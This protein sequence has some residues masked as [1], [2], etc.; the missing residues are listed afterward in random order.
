MKQSATTVID[1]ALADEL[2][3][4]I[5]GAAPEK[6]EALESQLLKM[7]QV[8]IPVKEGLANEMYTRE[9]LIP[10]GT[11]LTGRVHKYPYVDIMLSGDITVATPDGVKR[12]TGANVCDG[13]PGRKRAGFAH[14]DT[15]WVTVH[16]TDQVDL[17]D[18]IEYLTFVSLR[19]FHEWDDR[20]DFLLMAEDS[21]YTIQE[22]RA[23]SENESDRLDLEISTIRVADSGIEGL[24]LFANQPFHA[25]DVICPARVSGMRT[26]AGRYTNH[27]KRP[28]CQMVAY[29]DGNVFLKAIKPILANQELT[30]NY[31]HVRSQL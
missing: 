10:K 23:Q 21:G 25:G 14:Q 22:I 8:E 31:A 19:E 7:P 16:R 26:Q 30:V 5:S 29:P 24:G 9:I 28:N 3:D 13:V 17:D 15:R 4:L 6:I 1:R 2:T 27:S 18:M 20:Q 12:L 11:I